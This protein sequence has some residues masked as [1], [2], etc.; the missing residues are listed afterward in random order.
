MISEYCLLQID[1][2]MF[3]VLINEFEDHR[4]LQCVLIQNKY[5]EKDN[6]L[7]A[8]RELIWC[9]LPSFNHNSIKKSPY[10]QYCSSQAV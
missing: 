3:M 5:L 6:N 10:S 1:F 7:Y 2:K 4:S 9:N 8:L